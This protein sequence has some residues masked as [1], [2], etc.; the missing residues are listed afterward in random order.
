MYTRLVVRLLGIDIG[1]TGTKAIVVDEAGKVLASASARYP[2]M[3]PQPGWAEQDP[4]DWVRSV[5]ACLT[6]LD[7]GWDAIGLTGQMHGSVF[8]DSQDSVVRP[9]LLW[10]DQRTEAECREIEETV[11]SERIRT[12]TCNPPL[13]GFQLPKVLWLRKHEPEAFG[14]VRSVL[15]P[16]DYVAYRLT[17]VKATDVSDASGTGC[18]DV[19]RRVWSEDVIGAIGLDPRLY[20]EVHE[21]WEVTGKT[22]VGIPVVAGAGDQAAGAVGVGAVGPGVVSLSLG[23]S[24]VAFSAIDAAVPGAD[25][26]VHVFCH[27]NGGWHAMGVMLSCGGAVRWARDLLYPDM[28]FEEMAEE[29]SHVRPGAEGVRFL[30]YLAGERCPVVD[31]AARG[32]FAGL[33]LAHERAHVARAVFEGVTSGLAACLRKLE[34][35]GAST[36]RLRLTGGGAASPFWRQLIADATQCDCVA[37]ETDEG[38]AFGAALLAGVGIGV[39]PDV[40]SAVGQTVREKAACKPVGKDLGNGIEDQSRLYTHL[41]DWARTSDRLE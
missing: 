7:G 39:W 37:M 28:T 31:P 35:F 17:G 12:L 15:L 36:R 8:L 41:K 32:A 18:L 34:A 38:P 13:T 21:S 3:T 33:S 24:G 16:K 1:T 25:A 10:C 40:R 2:L 14:R 22:S 23:T 20:P 11:G 5:H 4:D 19:P 29:A 26:S 27:A 6:E 30:P 9:A